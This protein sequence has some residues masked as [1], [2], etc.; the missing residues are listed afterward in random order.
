MVSRGSASQVRATVTVRIKYFNCSRRYVE[1]YERALKYN[2]WATLPSRTPGSCDSSVHYSDHEIG[3]GNTH[4]VASIKSMM[5]TL[6]SVSKESAT[7]I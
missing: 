4:V 5:Y 7:T 3:F 2:E 1:M 6:V